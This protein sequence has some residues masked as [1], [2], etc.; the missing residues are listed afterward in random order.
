MGPEPVARGPLSASD[1]SIAHL[2]RDLAPQTS[3]I[4]VTTRRGDVEPLVRLNEID[5]HSS[6]SRKDHAESKTIFG[7][8]WLATTGRNFNA[9]HFAPPSSA[10]LPPGTD[11]TPLSLSRE[12]FCSSSAI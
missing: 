1:F 2:F 3:G 9:C 5:R 11:R 6:A 4:L 10:V 7:A 12:H 8:P